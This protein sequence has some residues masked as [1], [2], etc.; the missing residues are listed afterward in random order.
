[1]QRP[2]VNQVRRG[3][4]VAAF[5]HELSLEV[6]GRVAGLQQSHRVGRSTWPISQTLRHESLRLAAPQQ[7]PRRPGLLKQTNH[8]LRSKRLPTQVGVAVLASGLDGQAGVEQEH[9]LFGPGIQPTARWALPARLVSFQNIKNS[10]QRRPCAGGRRKSQA[11]GVTRAGVRVL[12]KDHHTHVLRRHQAKCTK[13]VVW[14][15]RLLPRGL[16]NGRNERSLRSCG[17]ARQALAPMRWQGGKCRRQIVRC[18]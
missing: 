3:R 2:P 13:W 4:E 17:P 5:V 15:N 9:T 8:N 18:H 10:A 6:V 7:E 11:V 14:R 1:M 16:A 12:T